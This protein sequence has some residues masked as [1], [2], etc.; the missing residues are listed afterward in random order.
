MR[1]SRPI[2]KINMDQVALFMVLL[3]EKKSYMYNVP[4]VLSGSLLSMTQH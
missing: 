3:E 2:L 4:Q 1:L